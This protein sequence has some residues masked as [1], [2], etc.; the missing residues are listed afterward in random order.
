MG[1]QNREDQVPWALEKLCMWHLQ[2]KAANLGRLPR[3]SLK[4]SWTFW[5]PLRRC[6]LR[7]HSGSPKGL[8]FIGQQLGVLLQLYG[9]KTR[10][11]L[12]SPV[13]WQNGLFQTFPWYRLQSSLFLFFWW[14]SLNLSTTLRDFP[15]LC[16]IPADSL[17]LLKTIPVCFFWSVTTRI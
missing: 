12:Y 5:P 2:G 16:P 1:I 14:V 8:G 3:S 17:D 15:R 7:S 9:F 13:I 6:C 11:P 10:A 4:E